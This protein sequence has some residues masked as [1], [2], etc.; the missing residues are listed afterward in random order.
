[1]SEI[2]YKHLVVRNLGDCLAVP[3]I[4]ESFEIQ[5]NR[6]FEFSQ[7]IANALFIIL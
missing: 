4:F 7:Q 2:Y 5:D 3:K 6:V 1:M